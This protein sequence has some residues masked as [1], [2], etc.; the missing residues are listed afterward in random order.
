MQVRFR[1]VFNIDE[2]VGPP[3]DQFPECYRNRGNLGQ[4][5]GRNDFDQHL[6]RAFHTSDTLNAKTSLFQAVP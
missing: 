6:I 5:L 3:I 1:Y 4:F 2:D